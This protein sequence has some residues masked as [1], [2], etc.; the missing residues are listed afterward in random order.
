MLV[1]D[2]PEYILRCVFLL[3]YCKL[4]L[5]LDTSEQLA[6]TDSINMWINVNRVVSCQGE[7]KMLVLAF[8]QF[9]QT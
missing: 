2:L 4:N 9:I 5:N 3:N 8:Y 7:F 1:A 6:R